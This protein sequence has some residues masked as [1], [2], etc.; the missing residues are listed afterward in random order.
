MPAG[1]VKA[2]G[3]HAAHNSHETK[4]KIKGTDGKEDVLGNENGK[5]ATSLGAASQLTGA[6]VSACQ[7][8]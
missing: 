2:L 6:S 5:E 4:K 3:K 7:E 8:P 1:K